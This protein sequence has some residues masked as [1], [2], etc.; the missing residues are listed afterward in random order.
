[1]STIRN[2]ML[3]VAP[4]YCTTRR[5][6]DGRG[7]NRNI[8]HAREAVAWVARQRGKTWGVI[9]REMRRHH[10]SVIAMVRRADGRR[11]ASEPFR[12]LTDSL[13]KGVANDMQ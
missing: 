10:S 9:G 5:E 7:T 4:V 12:E 13:L 2:L 3:V 11:R 6:M 1:M 8:V